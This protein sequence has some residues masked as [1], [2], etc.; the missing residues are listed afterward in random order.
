MRARGRHTAPSP[1]LN[2][3]RGGRAMALWMLA[4]IG[5][6][7]VM[8]AAVALVLYFLLRGDDGGD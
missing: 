5:L 6:G 1:G 2:E 4:V 3:G 8:L 7:V